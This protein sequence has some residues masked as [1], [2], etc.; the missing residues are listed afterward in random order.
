MFVHAVKELQKAMIHHEQFKKNFNNLEKKLVD[1]AQ[2]KISV[3]EKRLRKP[4]QR[5][6]PPSA[7]VDLATTTDA[8]IFCDTDTEPLDSLVPVKVE[9]EKIPEKEKKKTARSND[10]AKKAPRK[11]TDNLKYSPPRKKAKK[12][13]SKCNTSTGID[14]KILR[15]VEELKTVKNAQAMCIFMRFVTIT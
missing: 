6:Q 11:A 3:P 10:S 7:H 9:Q 1:D 14:E 12:S 13:P 2:K 4:T 15:E 5:Y 8:D